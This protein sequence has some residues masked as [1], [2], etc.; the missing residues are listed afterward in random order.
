MLA[1]RVAL[2]IRDAAI[3]K[4]AEDPIVLDVAKLTNVARYFVIT[5]GNSD[6]HVRAIA[7][8]IQDC[9]D[10]KKVTLWHAEG[11]EDGRWVLLDY[12]SVL[13]HIFYHQTREFYALERLWGEAK[14]L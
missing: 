3:D 5:H 1:K 6:R 9:M 12:G 10:D 13:A 4:K 11:M 8:N 7:Q 2:L 14:Q